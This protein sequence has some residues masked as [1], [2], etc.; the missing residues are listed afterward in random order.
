MQI[1]ITSHPHTWYDGR[2]YL[3]HK[4]KHLISPFNYY[5]VYNC[6]AKYARH[7]GAVWGQ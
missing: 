7:K 5:R 3:T 2:L 1:V 6:Y 4:Q